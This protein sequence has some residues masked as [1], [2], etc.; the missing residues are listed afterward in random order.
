M[1][2]NYTEFLNEG[3]LDLGLDNLGGDK[4]KEKAP[5][6]DKEIAKAKE[7]KRKKA[8]KKRAAELDE[9]EDKLKEA[10]KKTPSDFREKFEK[11]V[12][13]SLEDDDRVTYH[14]LI[15]DIQT[16][17]APKEKDGLQKE[18]EA[19]EPIIKILQDLNKNEYKG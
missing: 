18:V 10:F 19:S 9:A 5:D 7:K 17:E 11:R 14:D 1:L 13:D 16:F 15:T 8:E 12:L 4:K 2:K 6:P 3:G